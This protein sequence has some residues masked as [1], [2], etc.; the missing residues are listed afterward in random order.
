MGARKKYFFLLGF[1]TLGKK[2][3]QNTLLGGEKKSYWKQFLF[4]FPSRAICP[5]RHSFIPREFHS[6][7]DGQVLD[8]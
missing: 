8:A 1:I 4:L 7:T 6:S 3:G 5:G 2:I